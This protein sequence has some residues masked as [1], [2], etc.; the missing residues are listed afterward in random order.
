MRNILHCA[1]YNAHNIHAESALQIQ[2]ETQHEINTLH[3]TRMINT[4]YTNTL[5]HITTF[6]QI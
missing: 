5:E 4:I 1:G 6:M 2:E 3:I